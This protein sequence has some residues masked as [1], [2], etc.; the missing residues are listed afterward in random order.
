MLN[1][2]TF[3]TGIKKLIV[4]YPSWGIKIEDSDVVKLWYEQFSDMCNGDFETMVD[5]FIKNS[6]FYPSVASLR[7]SRQKHDKDYSNETKHLFIDGKYD[8]FRVT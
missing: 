2:D 7:E 8:P 6:K 4:F 1:K 5:S 3:K